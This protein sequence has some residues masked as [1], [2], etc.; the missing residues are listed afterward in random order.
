M[1]WYKLTDAQ[2]RACNNEEN[3]WQWPLPTKNAD[4]SWT[5]GAWT[6]EIKDVELYVSGYHIVDV[7]HIV[8]HKGE[9]LYEVEVA[10]DATWDRFGDGSAAAVSRCRLIRQIEAYGGV[11]MQIA[12]TQVFAERAAAYNA[13][14]AR[15]TTIK[16]YAIESYTAERAAAYVAADAV[17]AAKRAAAVAAYTAEDAIYTAED[18]T[19]VIRR[20]NAA[21]AAALA[22]ERHWQM[23]YICQ[24]LG[25]EPC[26]PK[27]VDGR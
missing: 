9:T 15:A 25:I 2:G 21:G 22:A 26:A 17:Y 3:H 18:A 6:P 16:S 24:Q 12:W 23:V 5:P 13:A 11:E 20:A 4:G 8:G 27:S 7:G 1:T 10:P 19:C 14:A